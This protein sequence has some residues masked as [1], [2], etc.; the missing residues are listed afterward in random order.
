MELG[1]LESPLFGLISGITEILPVSSEAHKLLF[2][3]ILG[4]GN[5]PGLLKVFI[6]IGVLAALYYHCASHILRFLR[7]KR[8]SRIPKR[9]R[10][11]PLD[12]KSL[13]DYSLL[14][15]MLIPIILSF[16][17]YD[18]ISAIRTDLILVACFLLLNGLILYIPQYL[19][20]SNKDSR[21]LSRVEG[22][23]MGLGGAAGI[24]PGISSLGTAC[25]VGAVCGVDKEYGLNMANLMN[26]A[27]VIGILFL[28]VFSLVSVGI[29]Y[30]TFT[31]FVQYILAA[32]GSFAGAFFGI[33]LLKR[34]ILEKGLAPFALY[35]WGVALFTFVLN[36]MA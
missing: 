30:V 15:T 1:W 2:L 29:G 4:A 34:I 13:M 9:K 19:P 24:L 25:S 36:L 11:R 21:M 23:L 10:K 27:M 32:A 16:F 5:E 31:I 18:R 20:G 17:A 33:S 22:F 35:C 7:A 8:L 6:H 12:T 3:K 28:D 26:L 14:K